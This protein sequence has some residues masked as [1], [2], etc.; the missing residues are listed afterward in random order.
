MREWYFPE[1]Y[2]AILHALPSRLTEG[3]LGTKKISSGRFESYCRSRISNDQDTIIRHDLKPHL[4]G[5]CKRGKVVPSCVPVWA[6]A[7]IG[8]VLDESSRRDSG[9]TAAPIS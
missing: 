3:A 6:Q 7:V 2:L 4:L 1:W 9:K 5:H 8:A